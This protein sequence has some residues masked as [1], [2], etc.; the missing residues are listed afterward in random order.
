MVVLPSV[1]RTKVTETVQNNKDLAKGVGE[2]RRNL[3]LKKE[4]LLNEKEWIH[5]QP[6]ITK[7][8][9]EQR[10]ALY[11]AKDTALK[12]SPNLS[13]SKVRLQVRNLPKRQFYEDEL[14]ELIITVM[15]AYKAKNAKVTTPSKKLIKQVKVMRDQVKEIQAT[16]EGAEALKLASGLAFVELMNA[17]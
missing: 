7:K 2:D 6:L 5:Q 15:D 4:G 10:R 8:D 12:K 17:E 11:I 14:R 9:L 16:E 13:V 1:A 3:A